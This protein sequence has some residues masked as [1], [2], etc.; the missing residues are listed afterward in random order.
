VAEKV[1]LRL[2]PAAAV[3]ARG[4]APKQEK[5]KAARGEVPFSANDLGTLLL[6]LSFDADPEVKGA[7][8]H[9]LREMPHD[10]LTAIADSRETHP[11]VLDLLARLH[12]GKGDIAEKL[13]H[14]PAVE[15]RTVEFLVS[16]GVAI[17]A[18]IPAVIFL[19][20]CNPEVEAD[21]G[22]TCAPEEDGGGEEEEEYKSKY[23]LCQELGVGEKI[24]IALS[25]DKEWRSILLKDSNKLVS[26]AAIKNPRITEGEVLAIAKSKVQ[27]DEIMRVICMNKE[28]LKNY[29]IRKALVENSKTPLPNALRF[30]STLTEKDL[31]AL[32][33][34]KNVGTVI[35]TQARRILMSKKKD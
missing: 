11:K 34:S 27:N 15:P 28:W 26:G 20:A 3:Y 13:L 7:A 10:L 5:L 35:S 4:D 1:T 29:Q 31:A 6:F 16:K 33:K 18:E 24:K 30:M 14:H 23:K 12:Y 9:S 17:P 2:S 32:A 22:E 21:V 25:G 8:V 19:E